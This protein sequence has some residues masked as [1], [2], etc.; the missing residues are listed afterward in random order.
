MYCFPLL[1]FL[2]AFY[3]DIKL[4]H[5]VNVFTPEYLSAN[6]KLH[7][8]FLNPQY[9]VL[10]ISK[11]K[12][13]NNKSFYRLL[14][15]LPGDISLNVGPV[16]EHQILNTTEWDIFKTKGLHLMHLNINSLLPKINELRHMARLSNAAV[17]GICEAKLDKSITNSEILIDNYDLLRCGWNRNGG[18]VA[19]Y[20]RNNLSYTQTNLFPN[21]IENVFFEIHL[22]ETKPITVGIVYRPPNQTNFIK[23]LNQNVAKLDKTNKET[24]ILGDFNINLCHNGKYIICKN[25]TL[26]LRSVTNDARNSSSVLYNVRLKTNNK[27]SDAY[28]LQ[29]YIFD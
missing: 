23:T 2:F 29:K 7:E 17:I 18:G 21:D 6:N 27:I 8:A 24:Y 28:N 19:C 3:N 12:Q 4:C 26:M 22:P 11:L 5:Q 20:I 1:I 15:I 14:V 25:N 10:T 16:C 13:I 9:T